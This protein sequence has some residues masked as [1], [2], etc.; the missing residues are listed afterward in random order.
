MNILFYVSLFLLFIVVLRFI[1]AFLN[2]LSR[3]ILPNGQPIGTPLVSV[4]IPARNEEFNIGKLL[5]GILNQSYK[6]IEVIVYNDQSTDQTAEIIDDYIAKDSRVSTIVGHELPKGWLGKNYGCYRL[7]HAAKGDYLIFLDADVKVSSTFV[8]N[9][10]A[11]SQRK[12]LVLLSMFPRQ[13]LVSFGEKLVVPTMNWI[14]L[15]ML[16]L[17]LVR[18]SK[19]R[20]LAAA[21][22]QMMMFDAK[23]YQ[24]QQWHEK[25]KSSPVEDI[26]I[27]RLIKRQKLRMATLLGTNDVSCRMYDSYSHAIT[28]F[29]KNVTAFFGGSIFVTVLFLLIGT[30]SPFIVILGLPFPLVLLFFFCLISARMLIAKLSGQSPIANLI[31][32]PLQHFAFIHLVFKAFFYSKNKNLKWKGRDIGKV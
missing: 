7:A 10:L 21:N 17:R 16:F 4:L 20:S 25:V 22:G 9:A 27:S 26:S 11:Y 29:T 18:W 8:Q 13:E 12:R 19:R 1:I 6:Q 5:D 2:F 24:E 32:W 23:V 14:L 15:S 31:L 28:G 30:F 3:P